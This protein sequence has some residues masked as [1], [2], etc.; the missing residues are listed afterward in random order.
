MN[1]DY[2]NRIKEKHLLWF[3]FK[4]ASSKKARDRTEL[5]EQY[6]KVSKELKTDIRKFLMSVFLVERD[7]CILVFNGLSWEDQV[8][9]AVS[10]A[11][12][13]LDLIKSNFKNIDCKTF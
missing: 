3:K 10:K 7:L 12:R 6:R 2:K 11:S 9:S 13:S 1:K 5:H 4:S 8:N